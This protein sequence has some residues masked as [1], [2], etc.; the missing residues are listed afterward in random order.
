[1]YQQTTATVVH[2]DP[3]I[4]TAPIEDSGDTSGYFNGGGLSEDQQQEHANDFLSYQPASHHQHSTHHNHHNHRA[5]HAE[6]AA[7]VPRLTH[8]GRQESLSAVELDSSSAASLLSPTASPLPSQQSSEGGWLSPSPDSSYLDHHQQHQ[9]HSYGSSGSTHSQQLQPP[10]LPLTSTSNGSSGRSYPLSS[11][12]IV[13]PN[14]S[15]P[16]SSSV[17]SPHPI[18][19]FAFGG[20][21]LIMFPQLT[22][23]RPQQSTK[24]RAAAA[25]VVA[26]MD[27]FELDNGSGVSTPSGGLVSAGAGC[28]R[29]YSLASVLA[30]CR[31]AELS[32]LSSFPGPFVAGKSAEKVG[33]SVREFITQTV[34]SSDDDSAVSADK[35]HT[36]EYSRLLWKLLG[37]LLHYQARGGGSA[38]ERER[39][40]AAVLTDTTEDR[41]STAVWK[42]KSTSQSSLPADTFTL[43]SS[44]SSSSSPSFTRPIPGILPLPTAPPVSSSASANSPHAATTVASSLALHEQR[45]HQQSI[46]A[47]LPVLLVASRKQEAVRLAIQHELFADAL[48][49]TADEPEMRSEV[50]QAVCGRMEESSLTRVHYAVSA[51]LEQQVWTQQLQVIGRMWP[52]VSYDNVD[53]VFT[54]FLATSSASLSSSSAPSLFSAWR[55]HA[56]MCVSDPS[57]YDTSFLLHLGDCLW[58]IFGQ[59]AAAHI[60]Y[61]LSTSVP[62]LLSS[63]PAP[64]ARVVLLGADHK[65]S[66]RSFTSIGALQATQLYE[67]LLQLQDGGT[68]VSVCHQQVYKFI[69]ATLLADLGQC[70]QSLRYCQAISQTV[71]ATSARKEAKDGRKVAAV[72]SS[73]GYLYNPLF[74]YELSILEHRLRVTLNAPA[75]SPVRQ[76]LVSGLFSVLDKGINMLVGDTAAA[77]TANSA[78]DK[79]SQSEWGQQGTKWERLFM[80]QPGH[81]GSSPA[82]GLRAPSPALSE[83]RPLQP[84]PPTSASVGGNVP[85]FA[86]PSAV[87]PRSSS[88]SQLS[89]QLPPQQSVL[90][91][92]P[93]LRTSHSGHNLHADS[94]LTAHADQLT[95]PPPSMLAAPT[96]LHNPALASLPGRPSPGASFLPGSAPP[97][98]SHSPLPPR[99]SSASPQRPTA[100]PTPTVAYEASGFSPYPP[101]ASSPATGSAADFHTA[102]HQHDS[103]S[104]NSTAF[105]SAPAPPSS[106]AP[107]GTAGHPTNAGA[108]QPGP[109]LLRRLGSVGGLFSMWGSAAASDG[110]AAAGAPAAGAA[111]PAEDSSKPNSRRSTPGVKE[112]NLDQDHS[113]RWDEGK[114]KYIFVDRHGNE[115]VEED[116][117]QPVAE[118]PAPPPPPPPPPQPRQPAAAAAAGMP[119]MPT[120]AYYSARP[121]TVNSRY[122]LSVGE[123]FVAPAAAAGHAAVA[124]YQPTAPAP[125]YAAPLPA[126]GAFAA[127]SP[128]AAA[129]SATAALYQPA[130]FGGAA[131]NFG[132]PA[133]PAA[134]RPGVGV[135]VGMFNPAA[136]YQHMQSQMPRVQQQPPQ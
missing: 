76:K 92:Q 95:F 60:C 12:P 11:S 99:P 93:T 116:K 114:Q 110:P 38:A 22:T 103:A 56:A 64:S 24:G 57:R 82:A 46:S 134:P 48:L 127:S 8:S 63:V 42:H 27:E 85:N 83:G 35:Q 49:L 90:Q 18:V 126:D 34:L 28:I 100:A 111:S 78:G 123:S 106:A 70:E 98:R 75:S 107:N 50:V 74:L 19:S 51:G 84:T 130:P 86:L 2:T 54:S 69:Y 81:I 61:L 30:E 53:Q 117:P 9:S 33:E 71:K 91:P 32:L 67:Y 59:P 112:A 65:R 124:A 39:D 94:E 125:L 101:K 23:T 26:Q 79:S 129:A 15:S 131:S 104:N 16:R 5:Q 119:A 43:S 29:L 73:D 115:V 41:D 128:P 105:T 6:S 17:R 3:P 58:S 14:P 80:P 55:S 21:M 13:G 108:A 45:L 89:A 36:G 121:H 66:L 96:N 47:Y 88:S 87:L 1:M 31:L 62:A 68:G 97:P 102:P 120:G 133:M 4:A 109:G 10:P 113:F 118:K 7:P 132:L 122:A 72:S 44:S 40:I 25:A 135:P 136:A 52:A 37:T 20:R 77:A